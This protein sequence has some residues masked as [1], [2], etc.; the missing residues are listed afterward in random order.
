MEPLMCCK[1]Q[2]IA[3]RNVFN[4]FLKLPLL[5]AGSLRHSGKEFQTD[6]PATEKAG[7][8]KNS[9]SKKIEGKLLLIGGRI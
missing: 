2:Y 8:Q 6:R 5:M 3:N 7:G 1:H 9:V 4:C